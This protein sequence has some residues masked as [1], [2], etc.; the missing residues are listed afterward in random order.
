MRWCEEREADAL[1]L[2]VRHRAGQFHT[3]NCSHFDNCSSAQPRPSPPPNSLL[4]YPPSPP[5]VHRPMM[6]FIQYL[7]LSSRPSQASMTRH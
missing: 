6:I 7:L 1:G 5:P 4:P 2:Q 3:A